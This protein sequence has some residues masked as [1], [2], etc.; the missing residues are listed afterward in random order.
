[1]T[2]NQV[3]MLLPKVGDIRME[4]MTVSDRTDMCAPERCV[5]VEVRPDRLW[6]RVRFDRTGSFECYKLPRSK[7]Q[8]VQYAAPGD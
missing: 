5:V 8:E 3:R 4:Q 6:Y 7:Y 2:K 1:M